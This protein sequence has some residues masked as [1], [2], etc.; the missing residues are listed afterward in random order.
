MPSAKSTYDQPS[1]AP[2][3]AVKEEHIEYGFIGTLQNLKYEYQFRKEEPRY[4][5][6]VGMTEIEKNDFNLNISRYIS[7]AV[8]E[9]E[10]DLN[11]TNKE[12][13]AIEKAI[14]AAKE[15]HNGFLKELGLKPLP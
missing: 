3:L 8:S 11:A 14:S 7:T 2:S 10:I 5:R 9:A 1:G 12:L 6:R 13:E 4:S 15:K